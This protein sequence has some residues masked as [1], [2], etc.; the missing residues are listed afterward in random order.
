[1]IYPPAC[2]DKLQFFIHITAVKQKKLNCDTNGI[3]L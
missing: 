3:Q 1:M 2:V